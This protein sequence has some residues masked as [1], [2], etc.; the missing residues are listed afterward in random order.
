[1]GGWP[2]IT[3]P[4]LRERQAMSDEEFLEYLAGLLEAIGT[5][6]LED[7]HYELA[8]GY[9][10]ERPPGSCFVTDEGVEELADIDA[11]R[12]QELVREYVY[13]SADR[14]PLLTYG[15]NGSPERL[16]LKLAHL[17]DG[18]RE[19]LILAG[20]LEGFDVGAAAQPPLFITMPATLI[21]SPGTAVRVAVLFLTP[22]Q[23][24]ALWWTELSYKVGRLTGITLTTDFTE[25][26]I[27][28][29]VLFVSRYG[30]FCVDGAPV[31]MAALAARDRRSTALTQIEIL[32]AAARMTLGEGC[33]ARD[34]IKAAFEHPATFMAERYAQI[35]G[36]LG[37][38]RVRALD[39]AAGGLRLRRQP[40]W[41]SAPSIV[42]TISARTVSARSLS[43]WQVPAA[44]WPPPP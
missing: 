33:A 14:I 10:W 26:P 39:G 42:S 38:V 25:E 21:P 27:E 24:T 3:E 37:P 9:P 19:A 23:F 36:C 8:I 4:L 7:E 40:R 44:S 16:A 34:L 31:A 12:R 22:V 1:M 43:I 29:V 15:A 13:E 32:D 17:P 2:E 20:Y 11:G 6:E 18:D 5:R 30:A 35:P 28:R 41:R